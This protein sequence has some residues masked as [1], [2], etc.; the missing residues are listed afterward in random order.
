MVDDDNEDLYKMSNEDI[1]DALIIAIELKSQ[2][3]KLGNPVNMIKSRSG[4]LTVPEEMK[5]YNQIAEA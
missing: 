3:N 5:E 4:M 2:Q 1:M